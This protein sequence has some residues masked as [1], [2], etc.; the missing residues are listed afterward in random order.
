MQFGRRIRRVM[1]LAAGLAM[2]VS[3][4][5]TAQSPHSAEPVVLD[6]M[7]AVV[8]NRA[9]LESD[10]EREVRLTILEPEGAGSEPRKDALERLISRILIQQQISEQEGQST[11]PPE[12]DVQA[13]VGE[14]RKELPACV[15]AKCA[16]DAGWAAFLKAHDL[17]EQQVENYLRLRMELLAF[18]EERFRQGIRISPEEIEDYYRNTLLPQYPGGETPPKLDSVRPRIEEILLQ[19]Q[20]NKLFGAWLENL[21]KQGDVE[22][23]DPALEPAPVENSGGGG[24][25]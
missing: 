12:E 6:K 9:I 5:A 13:R 20:V 24:H 8:N 16:T 17:T 15:R 14:L 2:G 23:F 4:W 1:C 21:R 18:I 25:A 7:V 3:A 10:V 19:Q 11:Q 22:I